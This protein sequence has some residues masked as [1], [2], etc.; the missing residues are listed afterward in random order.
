MLAVVTGSS[1]FVGSHL[2]EALAGAGWTVR[3]LVRPESAPARL[4]LPDALARRVETHAAPLTDAEALCRSPAFDGVDAV[5]H[6]AGVTKRRTLAEFRAGN[7]APT[8]ALLD[9]LAARGA[10]SGDPPPRFVFVSSQAAAGA[11]HALDRPR[12][13]RDPAEP[14]G[15]YGHSKREA[16]RL[17]A[18]H[19]GG[20]PWTILRPS[21]VYGP[22]DVD[23]LPVFRHAARGLALYPGTRDAWLS[24]VYV[25]DLARALVLAAT[26]P[27]AVGGTYF[28]AG[29]ERVPW[30]AVYEAAATAA[31]R[32]VR[33]ALDAPAF[34][35]AAAGMAGDAWAALTHRD[36][37]V[38]R[39]KLRLGRPRWW[40]C[41]AARARLELGWVPTVGLADGARRTYAW[42]RTQG[43]L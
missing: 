10:T 43:L 41:S 24:M 39:E 38:T 27:Q 6:V 8:A 1:G 5:L 28:V 3:R 21:A 36:V 35:L 22:R 4:A 32:R 17:V 13:E 30:P 2:V 16:E 19:P 23:F 33:W 15:A 18:A 29:D 25:G 12:T 14:V 31:G 37:L 11:A 34:A 42:Y 26:A 9:A 7:V 20:V 40:C